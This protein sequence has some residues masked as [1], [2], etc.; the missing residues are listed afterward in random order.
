VW[1]EHAYLKVKLVGKE[2]LETTEDLITN[3]DSRYEYKW[4]GPS[5]KWSIVRSSDK[6]VI[7]HGFKDKGQAS[8]RIVELEK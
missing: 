2:E 1:A 6:T 4:T 8:A 3:A 7:E 5:H